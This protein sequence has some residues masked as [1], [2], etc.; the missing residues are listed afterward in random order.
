MASIYTIYLSKCN[1]AHLAL[2]RKK[3]RSFTGVFCPIYDGR[4]APVFA[5]YNKLKKR[6]ESFYENEEKT[7]KPFAGIGHV[8][9]PAPDN[10]VCTK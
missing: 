8:C 6:K 2:S 3:Y 10:S 4:D 5:I 7:S 9:V 1:S